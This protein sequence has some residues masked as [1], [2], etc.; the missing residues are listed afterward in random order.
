MATGR[1][2]RRIERLLDEMEEAAGSKDW[3]EVLNIV[4]KLDDP[5]SCFH[6]EQ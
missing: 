2:K 3:Q 5:L 1:I 6:R 4:E